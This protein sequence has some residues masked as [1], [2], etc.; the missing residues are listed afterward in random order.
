MVN[1][2]LPKSKLCEAVSYAANQEAWL[3]NFLLDGR[4]EISNNR[5]ENSIRPFTIGRKNWLF[6]YCKRGAEASAVVY[7]IVE[8]AQANGLVPFMYL[9]YLCQTLPN[10]PKEQYVECLPWNPAV[11]EV[12]QIN[13]PNK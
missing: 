2:A 5:A 9:N 4:L 11:R 1:K 7:S 10:I 3:M 6:S 13:A 12:C 8:T